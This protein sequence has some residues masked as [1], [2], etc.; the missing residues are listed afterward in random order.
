MKE[1]TKVLE[2]ERFILK[3]KMASITIQIDKNVAKILEKKAKKNL[4]TLKEQIEDIVRKSAIRSKANKKR[5]VPKID[6]KLVGIFSRDK[7]GR[8]KKV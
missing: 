6:D 3:N 2:L 7:K 4:L 5:G 8:K 1:F